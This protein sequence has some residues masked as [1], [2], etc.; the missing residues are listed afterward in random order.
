MYGFVIPGNHGELGDNYFRATDFYKVIANKMGKRFPTLSVGDNPQGEYRKYW[1]SKGLIKEPEPTRDD[2]LAFA[3]IAP[4]EKVLFLIIT[5][6]TPDAVPYNGV[7][8]LHANLQVR[9]LLID[10]ATQN[11]VA[12]RETTQEDKDPYTSKF[13]A[14]IS[15]F[16]LVM[17]YFAKNL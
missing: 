13:L 16:K 8:Y 1:D 9:A 5:S 15:C 17:E 14:Q 11:I 10:T 12:D 2:L 3:K 6:A 7:I 4:Y